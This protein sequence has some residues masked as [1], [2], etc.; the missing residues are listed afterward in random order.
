MS[1]S[2]REAYL[3]GKERLL[4]AEVPE[5]EQ[6]ARLLLEYVCGTDRQ[7]M[8][9]APERTLTEAEEA[10]YS[11]VEVTKTNNVDDPSLKIE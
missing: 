2:Y 8:L 1:I 4:A 11:E 5:A 10:R 9:L 7:A 3:Q 6:N